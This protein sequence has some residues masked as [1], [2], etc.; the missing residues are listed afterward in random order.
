MPCVTRVLLRR[1]LMIPPATTE[2]ML[3][4]VAPRSG[5]EKQCISERVG[6]PVI[7]KPSNKPHR[8]PFETSRAKRATDS[9]EDSEVV[10]GATNL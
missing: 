6:L 4:R 5:T 9:V 10:E 3:V 7:E 8:D 2:R 1:T